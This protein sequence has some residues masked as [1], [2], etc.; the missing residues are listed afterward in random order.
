M[1][2]ITAKGHK[3][4]SSTHKATLEVTKEDFL[5]PQA[6]CIIA[7][8]ADK[9]LVD[10]DEGLKKHLKS[11]G[12]ILVEISCDG[13][14]EGVV[15]Y[16][17]PRLTFKSRDSIVVRKSA[18]VCGRTLCIR[19]DKSALDLDRELIRKIRSGAEVRIRMRV[20]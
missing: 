16:G 13:I 3:N 17:D 6:D 7:V 14:K 9:G 10:L 19:A 1:F 18:F 20:V 5:T 12:K 8:S 15:G 2:L 4:V 11:G